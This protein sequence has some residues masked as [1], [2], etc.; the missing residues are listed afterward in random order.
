[1]GLAIFILGTLVVLSAS[2]WVLLDLF[3]VEIGDNVLVN[4]L[5][6]VGILPFAFAATATL[7]VWELLTTR[8]ID[9]IKELWA[10]LFEN[11]VS[12]WSSGE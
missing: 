4:R 11:I 10:D 9:A 5:I 1:M 8:S 2:I 7:T 12:T 3:D 6:V